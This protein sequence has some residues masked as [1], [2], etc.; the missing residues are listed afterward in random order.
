MRRFKK[1]GRIMNHSTI[2]TTTTALLAAVA[3]TLHAID[4]D[5]VSGVS[6]SAKDIRELIGKEKLEGPVEWET[7]VSAGMTSKAGNTDSESISGG[8]ET[9]KLLGSTLLRAYAEGEYETTQAVDEDGFILSERTVGNAKAAINVKERFD[10][11]F[12]FVDA[13]VFHDDMA[14]VRYRAIESVG[15][16]VFIVD[17][18]NVKFS[19]ESG[20]AYIHERA[21]EWDDYLGQRFAE[22]LDWKV[23]DTF[24]L[25]ETVEAIPEFKDAENVLASFEVGVESAVNQIL[26]LA[27]KLKM[28]Y[29]SDPSEGIERTDRAFTTQITYTF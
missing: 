20:L 17:T 10:D 14:G 12:L 28:E 6:T 22:R 23:N 25:W 27:V 21:P 8:V 11:Y 24:R 16:G 4:A 29:D 7:K 5:I 26:S 9:A 2:K 15:L 3:A 1:N 19:V 18:D 13:S